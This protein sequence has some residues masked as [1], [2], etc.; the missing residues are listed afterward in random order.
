MPDGRSRDLAE[1]LAVTA[2]R[3]GPDSRYV[4]PGTEPRYAPDRNFSA[5]HMRLELDLD[6]RARAAA[7][8][9]VTTVRALEDGLREL[10][11]D[12]VG[13]RPFSV[14]SPRGGSARPAAI[15]DTVLP[16]GLSSLWLGAH[17]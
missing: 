7:G 12:A 11:F 4:L 3:R 2:A 1:H 8:R 17:P 6:L 16:D 5:T 15:G 9:C 13:F 14:V 10:D